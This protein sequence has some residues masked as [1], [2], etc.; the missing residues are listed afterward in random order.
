MNYDEMRTRALSGDVILLEGTGFVSKAIRVLTGQS[1]SHIALLVW[2]EGGL[3]IAEMV[4][5]NGYVIT[6][7]SQRLKTLKGIVYFGAAPKVVTVEPEKVLAQVLEYRADKKK[8]QYGYLSLLKVWW[9]QLV[10]KSYT[11]TRK[12]CSTFVQET[13]QECGFTFAQTADPGDFMGHCRYVV[14]MEV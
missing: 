5:G 10:H 3:F 14:K 4:E 1:I 8:Q 2:M 6:P 12:V 9:A 11:P 7:A 13:W